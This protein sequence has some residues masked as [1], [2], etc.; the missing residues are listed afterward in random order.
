MRADLQTLL[1]AP[2]LSSGHERDNKNLVLAYLLM[3]VYVPNVALNVPS[4]KGKVVGLQGVNPANLLD[5]M[6]Q[7]LAVNQGLSAS[8]PTLVATAKAAINGPG[9]TSAGLS[10]NMD[11]DDFVTLQNYAMLTIA[12]VL[13]D[14]S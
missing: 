2:P 5:L 4:V 14:A 11:E 13:N 10:I 9:I 12:K 6:I 1:N 7:G 8:W 3:K